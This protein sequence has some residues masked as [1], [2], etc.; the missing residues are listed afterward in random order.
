MTRHRH[1]ADKTPKWVTRLPIT[2]RP[3]ELPP[4]L[5]T[6]MIVIPYWKAGPPPTHWNSVLG[7][8]W[9]IMIHL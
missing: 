1:P 3:E 9:A 8:I 4:S 2:H 6:G 5:G 7:M